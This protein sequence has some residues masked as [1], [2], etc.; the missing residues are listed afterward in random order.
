MIF[1]PEDVKASTKKPQLYISKLWV[2]NEVVKPNSSY[3]SKNIE[4]ENQVHLGYNDKKFELEFQVINYN[5]NG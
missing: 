1:N 4:V 3:I 2:N 5:N